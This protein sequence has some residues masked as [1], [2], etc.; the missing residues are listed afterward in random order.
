VNI[1][2]RNAKTLELRKLVENV[3][4]SLRIP[5][6]A[7][8]DALQA[9][10]LSV[11]QGIEKYDPAKS[12]QGFV[13]GS[14]RLSIARDMLREIHNNEPEVRA[15]ARAGFRGMPIDDTDY[16][17]DTDDQADETSWA[18]DLLSNDENTDLEQSVLRERLVDAVLGLKDITQRAILLLVL[19]G[20]TVSD[21]AREMGM[22]QSS[23]DRSYQRAV[24]VLRKQLR[25]TSP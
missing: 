22:S 2:E 11:L 16:D 12:W 15:L 8:E 21:A 23:A 9:G 14:L 3:A 24:A 10:Y 6:D 13:N 19:T 5:A 4:R 20:V 17:S 18:S 1:E 7:R 25:V